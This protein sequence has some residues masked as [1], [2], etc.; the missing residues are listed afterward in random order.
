MTDSEALAG[1]ALPSHLAAVLGPGLSETVAARLQGIERLRPRLDQILAARLGA[2]T[3][4]DAVQAQ[5]MGMDTSS[6]ARLASEAGAVWHAAAIARLLDGEA[7]RA[8]VPLI[9]KGLWTVA[10]RGY[11]LSGPATASTPEEIA[12]AIPAD[13]AA[14]LAAW[15]EAQP[16]PVAGRVGLRWAPSVP[17]T[18]GAAHR[19]RGPAIL[20]WLV[21]A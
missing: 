16:P 21:L 17:V 2:V 8:L 14:C 19:E 4:P 9:G 7:V 3:E 1:T 18:P 12:S 10:L 5:V 20:A 13:G 6:L 15:C 11:T